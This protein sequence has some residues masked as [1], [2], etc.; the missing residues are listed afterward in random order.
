MGK[1][2][3]FFGEGRGICIFEKQSKLITIHISWQRNKMNPIIRLLQRI[4]GVLEEQ[5]IPY[6]V[7]G[8][9]VLAIY[10][11][12]RMTRDIDIV[13]AL[14]EEKIELFTNQFSEGFYIFKPSIIEEVKRK[15][16]FNLIDHQTGFKIDFIVRKDDLYRQTEFNRRIYSEALGFQMQIVTIEDL[17]ISKLIW[18]Q[19]LQS[20]KQIMDIQDLLENPT[21]DKN[22][23]L[24]WCKYLQLNTFNLV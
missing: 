23:L 8:S 4:V 15:G 19:E 5:N 3:D 6:M 2:K 20:E 16:M 1:G 11:T 12:P 9:M 22:Y 17:I 14:E 18:T 24:H 7:S 21:I 10:A 13:I